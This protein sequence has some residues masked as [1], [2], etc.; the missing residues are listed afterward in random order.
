MEG[1]GVYC[2]DYCRHH[3]EQE[4][5]QQEQPQMEH[6]NYNTEQND[7]NEHHDESMIQVYDH[8]TSSTVY[9]V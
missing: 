4:Q 1:D 8:H 7:D 2:T 9:D 6:V 3:Q 5:Q